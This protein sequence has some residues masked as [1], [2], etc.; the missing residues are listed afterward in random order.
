MAGAMMDRW[1]GKK[2]DAHSIGIHDDGEAAADAESSAASD[3]A[4]EGASTSDAAERAIEQLNA[5]DAQASAIIRS[6]VAEN[7]A[8]K[9][10][11]SVLREELRR[12]QPVAASPPAVPVA[13]PI[14]LRLAFAGGSLGDVPEQILRGAGSGAYSTGSD[15]GI[16]VCFARI[17]STGRSD[18]EALLRA[19]CPDTTPAKSVLV[20][21][22]VRPPSLPTTEKQ[23]VEPP[24][25][26]KALRDAGATERTMPNI[27]NFAVVMRTKDSGLVALDARGI[28]EFKAALADCASERA[29]RSR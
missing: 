3:A 29:S 14:R 13:P 27:V 21:C 10:E 16:V 2:A 26:R 18:P 7:E 22:H 20:L 11:N 12:L 4:Q 8:L 5:A 24:Y 15:T 1:L 17:A 19:C 28:A 6:L 25:L 9:S 23:P